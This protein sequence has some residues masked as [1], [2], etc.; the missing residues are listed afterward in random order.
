M[1]DGQLGVDFVSV[2]PTDL[3]ARCSRGFPV[4]PGVQIPQDLQ[5]YLAPP[6]VVE[7]YPEWR[8]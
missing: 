5:F 2:I 4:H 7:I 1:T 6:D 8:G 3:Y